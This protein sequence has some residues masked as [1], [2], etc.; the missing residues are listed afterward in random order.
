MPQAIEQLLAADY[1]RVLIQPLHIL[2]GAEYHQVLTDLRPYKERFPCMAV[3]RPLLTDMADYLAAVD[4]LRPELPAPVLR[5]R[6][7]C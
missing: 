5:T 6:P 7:S 4:A 2:N 3:G 1:H